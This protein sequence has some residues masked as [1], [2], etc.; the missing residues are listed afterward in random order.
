MDIPDTTKAALPA[1]GVVLQNGSDY[2]FYGRQELFP[3]PANTLAAQVN[4]VGSDIKVAL[5]ST[6]E[7]NCEYIVVATGLR[8]VDGSVLTTP[9]V[10]VFLGP[11]SPF[12]C[13]LNDVLQELGSLA[14]VFGQLT[15]GLAVRNA[16]LQADYLSP[17]TIDP[18]NITYPVKQYVRFQAAYDLLATF[19]LEKASQAGQSYQLD[20][21]QV[22]YNRQYLDDLVK[23][24]KD[25]LDK[26]RDVLT[27][28]NHRGRPKARAAVRGG[29]SNPQPITPRNF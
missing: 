27:G 17:T 24:I 5:N 29:T 23:R 25:E 7:S 6:P 28:Y 12:Y 2:R 3:R 15:V 22:T 13:S 4:A 10:T 11:L 20:K 8:A 21:L 19:Y 9:V 26:W 1:Q 18:Q 14:P 16:S